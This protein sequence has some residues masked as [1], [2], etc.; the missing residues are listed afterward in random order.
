MCNVLVTKVCRRQP[1]N[2]SRGGKRRPCPRT[3]FSIG[4]RAAVSNHQKAF[5]LAAAAVLYPLILALFELFERPGLGIGHF[6]YFPVAMIALAMGAG[7]GAAAGVV[8][9]GFYLLGIALNQHVWPSIALNQHVGPTDVPTAG[10]TIRFLTYTS[11]GFV[12]GWFAQ[13]R[14]ELVDRLQAAA[15]EDFLTGLP[16]AR[17]F[18]AG[19]EQRLRSQAPFGLILGDLDKLKEVNDTEGH[20]VGNAILRRAGE[21]LE[22]AIRAEDRLARIGGDEFAIGRRPGRGPGS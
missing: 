20:A 6:Y 2:P 12:V 10:T 11:I 22:R 9:T 16:N 5:L 18:D 19:V 13:N 17:A 8:A 21:I 4:V 7:W 15:E 14:R 1:P 3:I